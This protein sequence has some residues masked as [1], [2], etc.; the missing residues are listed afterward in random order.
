MQL[1]RSDGSIDY[2]AA[3]YGPA[4][5]ALKNDFPEDLFRI[6]HIYCLPGFVWVSLLFRHRQD[7]RNRSE[8]SFRSFCVEYSFAFFQRLPEADGH[9]FYNGNSFSILHPDPVDG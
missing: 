1:P 7:K 8:K 9:S 3:N 2:D 6:F 4:A 5:E